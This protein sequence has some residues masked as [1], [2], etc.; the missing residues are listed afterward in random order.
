MQRFLDISRPNWTR[1]VE[2]QGLS[3]HTHTQGGVPAPYWIEDAH[4]QFSMAEID[5]IEQ[6][7]NDL[8]GMCIKAAERIIEKGWITTR[9]ALPESAGP[10]I[11]AS[12]EKEEKSLYGRVD[13][14][15][16]PSLSEHPKFL[17]YN[18]DTPTGL[19]EAAVIQWF[20]L[21]DRFPAELERKEV[22][23]FNSIH[24]SLIDTWKLIGPDVTKVHFTGCTDVPEE[25]QTLLYLADTASQAGK[26]VELI[27][28][29]RIGWNASARRFWGETDPLNAIFKLYPWEDLFLEEFGK[30]LGA[31]PTI[32]I[33]P[34]WKILIAN[35][36]ILPI[37]W[38]MYPDHPNLLPAYDQ[39]DRLQNSF[40]KKALYSREGANMVLRHDGKQT[41]T[42]GRYADGPF[43]YQA[44]HALPDFNGNRPVIGSWLVNHEAHGMGIRESD[45]EI[46]D[47]FSRFVP[48]I[49][50]DQPSESSFES[51]YGIS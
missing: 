22:D 11:R 14:S 3:Y 34:A 15:Y 7:T 4:Y 21:A 2:E 38:E 42:G 19:L 12:W 39:P 44:Y 43:I 48:H 5:R 16:N 20:W 26:Q 18:A 23:Q 41:V 33:E 25:H 50:R 17:E 13:F 27:D 29:A 10:L 28:I 30:Y 6:V 24:E 32:W 8:H 40:T 9:L 37:L 1:R 47:N 35:K 51:E 36:A 49:I 46:T 31:S 45:T